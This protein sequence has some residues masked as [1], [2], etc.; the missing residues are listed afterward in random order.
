MDEPE[1]TVIES[2][3]GTFKPRILSYEPVDVQAQ[4]LP[5]NCPYCNR[6]GQFTI[7]YK[8]RLALYCPEC[9]LTYKWVLVRRLP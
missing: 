3:M 1:R 6:L 5:N 9:E 7:Q 8:G 2:V 4:E